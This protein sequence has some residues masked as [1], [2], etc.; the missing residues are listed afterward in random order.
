MKYKPLVN[1]LKERYGAE[2]LEARYQT[3]LRYAIVVVAVEN[4]YASWQMTSAD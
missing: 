2:G 3:E 4:P 1:C